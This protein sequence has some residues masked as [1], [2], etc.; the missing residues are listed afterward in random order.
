MGG[1]GA[2]L[3]GAGHGSTGFGRGRLEAGQSKHTRTPPLAAERL[4][5][6]IAS[7]QL[8][9]G[10][11]QPKTRPSNAQSASEI[12][13]TCRTRGV[14]RLLLPARFGAAR[15][16]GLNTRGYSGSSQVRPNPSHK[17]S[18]N[19]R[20]PGPVWRYAVHFRQPGPGVLP[21]SPA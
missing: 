20:P 7:W 17:R 2:K 9:K 6:A 3:T 4:T 18:A 1:I 16:R 14:P 5:A 10:R 8:T 12:P 19:G 15:I 21:S 11:H 13:S